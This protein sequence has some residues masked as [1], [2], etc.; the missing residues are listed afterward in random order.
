MPRRLDAL[1]GH[2]LDG[3]LVEAAELFAPV[4][5]H[6]VEAGEDRVLNRPQGGARSA[7]L[8]FGCRGPPRAQVAGPELRC[9][10]VAFRVDPDDEVIIDVAVIA[11]NTSDRDVIDAAGPI[12]HTHRRPPRWTGN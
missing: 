4:A 6:D 1:D 11:S 7:D 9:A 2:E 8:H 10:Q 5:G 12:R 3:P